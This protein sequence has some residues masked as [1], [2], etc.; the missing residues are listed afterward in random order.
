MK[1]SSLVCVGGNCRVPAFSLLASRIQWFTRSPLFFFLRFTNNPKNCQTIALAF[2]FLPQTRFSLLILTSLSYCS[3]HIGC[4]HSSMFW[5]DIQ[6]GFHFFAITRL[7][8]SAN[9]TYPLIPS[10]SFSPHFFCAALA[11]I[12]FLDMILRSFVHTQFVLALISLSPFRLHTLSEC[13]CSSPHFVCCR[14][15]S[16]Y[17]FV[18]VLC[19]FTQKRRKKNVSILLPH[20]RGHRRHSRCSWTIRTLCEEAKVEW[21]LIVRLFVLCGC[22]NSLSSLSVRWDGKNIALSSYPLLVAS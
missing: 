5:Y 7:P 8:P 21:I 19:C 3:I 17:S 1:F 6:Q 9:L 20:P 18:E 4:M 14:L 16:S 12:F 11:W 22:K 15:S 10:P 13:S 2:D